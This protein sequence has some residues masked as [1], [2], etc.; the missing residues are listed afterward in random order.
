MSLRQVC[1]LLPS[2]PLEALGVTPGV[3]VQG[4]WYLQED[5]EDPGPLRPPARYKPPP[6]PR[7]DSRAAAL[8]LPTE[9]WTCGCSGLCPEAEPGEVRGGCSDLGPGWW[10]D[11]RGWPRDPRTPVEETGLTARSLAGAS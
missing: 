11:G 8:G 6:A 4:D 5:E 9:S 2:V 7:V 1:T 10:G 3:G